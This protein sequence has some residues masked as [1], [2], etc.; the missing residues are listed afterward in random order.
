MWGMWREDERFVCD[1]YNVTTTR[2]AVLQFTNA[3]RDTAGWNEPSL[4]SCGGAPASLSAGA[5]K[6]SQPCYRRI[7][8]PHWSKLTHPVPSR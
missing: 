1:L 7:A 8:E 3:F 2:D 4:T 5:L 6:F